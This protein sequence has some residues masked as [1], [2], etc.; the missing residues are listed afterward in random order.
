MGTFNIYSELLQI[1]V[2]NITIYASD[3]AS[4]LGIPLKTFT[5]LSGYTIS[6]ISRKRSQ[7]LQEVAKREKRFQK[8]EE[9]EEL[10]YHF[11]VPQNMSYA[12]SLLMTIDSFLLFQDLDSEV[13]KNIITRVLYNP[14]YCD[15]KDGLSVF[16]SD[17]PFGKLSCQDWYVVDYLCGK[18]LTYQLQYFIHQAHSFSKNNGIPFADSHLE[19]HI[20][21]AAIAFTSY[22]YYNLNPYMD[23]ILRGL[24]RVYQWQPKTNPIFL[25]SI[26]GHKIFT[27][28]LEET[29]LNHQGFHINTAE[30]AKKIPSPS[31]NLAY[32]ERNEIAS[33]F[34]SQRHRSHLLLFTENKEEAESYYH[35]L[36][37]EYKSKFI[38]AY[39]MVNY[40]SG[41]W[42][43]KLVF[44]YE[45]KIYDSKF[46]LVDATNRYGVWRTEYY[47]EENIYE[48]EP[49]EN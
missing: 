39:L 48:D 13:K 27:G 23:S 12:S 47:Q 45:G 19:Q 20:R 3:I 38:F 9:E 17:T 41:R 34:V 11:K 18:G 15:T 44:E 29:L 30:S 4:D 6:A 10:P 42:N 5:E 37:P 33:F 36:T 16:I 14:K 1:M 31:E 26:I 49:S 8:Q 7:E 21:E 32:K 2:S 40:S 43:D 25:S 22:G 46:T 28:D 35:L 24:N